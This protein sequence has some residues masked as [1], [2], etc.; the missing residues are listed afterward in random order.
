LCVIAA[1]RHY[2]AEEWGAHGHCSSYRLAEGGT[3][4]PDAFMD[5]TVWESSMMLRAAALFDD[6]GQSNHVAGRLCDESDL[7]A[8]LI[9]LK[10]F[11]DDLLR[12]GGRRLGACCFRRGY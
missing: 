9:D 5:E 11:G 1:S 3:P 8:N 6:F 12:R 10:R 2:P 4:S 7:A